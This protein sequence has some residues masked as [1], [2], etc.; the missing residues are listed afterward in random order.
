MRERI[1]VVDVETAGFFGTPKVYDLGLAVVE[2]TTGKVLETASFIIEEV[3][4]GCKREMKTAHYACKMPQY[5]AGIV[6][7]KWDVVS[8]R[9]ARDYVWGLMCLHNINRVYAYNAAF[10]KGALNSTIEYVSGGFVTEFFPEGTEFACIWHA[11]C[12]TIMLQRGFRPFCEA[13]GFVSKAG[14]IKTSAEVCYAY[15]KGDPAYAE[16]HTGLEDVLIETEI[17]H[18]AIRQHKPMREEIRASCW[19]IPQEPTLRAF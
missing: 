1:L 11:A 8:L 3:F 16:E 9:D 13:N 2:R 15:I 12:T 17:L 14:N 6:T 5:H 4:Y 19:K 10:D 7:G 18:W